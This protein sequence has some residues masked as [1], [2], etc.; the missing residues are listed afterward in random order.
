[1]NSFVEG[2]Q[3]VDHTGIARQDGLYS[4]SKLLWMKFSREIVIKDCFFTSW[5]RNMISCA[6]Q[7]A[8]NN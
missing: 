5:N 1:M 2:V 4:Q 3:C 8:D 7:V 6:R